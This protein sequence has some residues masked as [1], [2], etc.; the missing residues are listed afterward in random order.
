MAFEPGPGRTIF[1]DTYAMQ[2]CHH[3]NRH[4][5]TQRQFA[6]AAAKNHCNGAKNE[7]AQYRFEMTVDEVMQ[8]RPVSYP[9]TRSMCSPIGDGAAAI[10]VTTAERG[11]EKPGA[12]RVAG[13]A[14]A[15]GKPGSGS[16]AVARAAKAAYEQAAIGPEEIGVAEVHDAA[17]SAELE[18]IENLGLAQEGEAFRLNEAG[19]TSLGGRIPVNVS[20]GLISR[21]HPVGA[22]GARQIDE[23]V[24]PLRGQAGERQVDP[25]PRFGISQ[26]GGGFIGDDVAAAMVTILAA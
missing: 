21:G 14:G 1:M 26:N 10:V 3:M 7:K 24:N 13:T 16:P 6:I 5:S 17:A 8:D 9:L 22:T 12:I 18:E 25:L 15:S 2:A 23:N 4:G 20:G 19:A 11:S